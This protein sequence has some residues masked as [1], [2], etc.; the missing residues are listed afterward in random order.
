ARNPAN[1]RR[2]TSFCTSG[3]L[4]SS[5]RDRAR[6]AVTNGQKSR[7][8]PRGSGIYAPTPFPRVGQGGGRPSSTLDVN[9][10]LDDRHRFWSLNVA[11]G[12]G[13]RI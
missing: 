11:G 8:R 4:A 3:A 2:D 6:S 7:E 13:G 1:S 5:S 12:C 9:P 10:E